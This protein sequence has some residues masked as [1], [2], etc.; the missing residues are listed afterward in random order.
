MAVMHRFHPEYGEHMIC[1]RALLHHM[2]PLFATPPELKAIAKV[3]AKLETLGKKQ[4]EK[5]SGRHIFLSD[6]YKALSED[7]PPGTKLSQEVRLKVFQQH[8]S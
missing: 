8:S 1:A 3:Q 2:R 6:C 7:Q 4:P 5:V